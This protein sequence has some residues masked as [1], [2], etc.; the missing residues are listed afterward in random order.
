V[1]ALSRGQIY[2]LLATF[3][4]ALMGVIVK[5]LA[6]LPTYEVV[7][8]RAAVSLLI[9]LPSLYVMKVSPWGVNR[10]LLLA[11][12][13]VGTIGLFIFF[14]TLTKMPLASAY[15]IQQLS[16]LFTIFIA[17]LW[18]SERATRMEWALFLVAFGGVA[19]VQ[20]FDPRVDLSIALIGVVGAVASGFAYNFVRELRKTD[21]TLVITFYFPLVAVI[22]MGP[23]T[24]LN[25]HPLEPLDWTLLILLGVCTFLGQ[26]LLT[27]AIQSDSISNVSP[28]IYVGAIFS[29]GFGYFIFDE[30]MPT[31][32]LL[33][34][35]VILLSLGLAQAVKPKKSA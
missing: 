33:G 8:F 17:G 34:I 14:Y 20:G 19:L 6:H 25:W 28:L 7:F 13:F 18:R 4:F 12:G 22:L 5:F 35:F 26:I 2:M 11:R 16:P 31:L 3:W 9:C 32:A 29:L 27:K 23:Y 30:T 24:L 21:H 15:T 10:P 1:Q